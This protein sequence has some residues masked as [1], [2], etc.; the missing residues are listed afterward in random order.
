MPLVGEAMGPVH[1]D[2][3]LVAPVEHG[4]DFGIVELPADDADIAAELLEV[5]DDALAGAKAAP[6][7]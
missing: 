3:D 1:H 5:V 6:S 7:I 4:V 2:E